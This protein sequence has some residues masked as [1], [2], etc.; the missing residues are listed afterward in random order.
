ME[1]P[2]VTRTGFPASLF[3]NKVLRMLLAALPLICITVYILVVRPDLTHLAGYGYAGVFV[4]MMV[5]NATVLLPLP[6][7]A[8]VVTAGM[9]WNPFLVGLA[10]GL[11]GA[12][13]ELT[14]YL[15]GYGVHEV[16][17]DSRSRWYQR[18]EAFVRRHGFFAILLLAAVPNPLFDVVGVVA[19]S[20]SYPAWRFYLAVAIG[21]TIKSTTI[22]LFGGAVS[23]RLG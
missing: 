10:G 12:L 9:M 3:Q 15:A 5:A 7:I 1:N 4:I 17:E 2:A 8:T 6:G 11:G 20:L 23:G 16:L 19:G 13:G 18:I 22:A 14:G 21:N